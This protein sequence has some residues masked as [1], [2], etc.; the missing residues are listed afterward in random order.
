M[1]K[2]ENSL[3][4]ARERCPSG[5]R[6]AKDDNAR[7]L[8]HPDVLIEAVCWGGIRRNRLQ[9]PLPDDTEAQAFTA[10]RRR[11][12]VH[13]KCISAHS[14]GTRF[15]RVLTRNRSLAS[16]NS[17]NDRTAGCPQKASRKTSRLKV[18]SSRSLPWKPVLRW[19][20]EFRQMRLSIPCH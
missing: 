5:L 19:T 7:R 8:H 16:A 13:R 15:S 14:Q 3:P 2:I 12:G 20:A 9:F 4:A 10:A 6:D 18:R 17:L 11:M 1:T